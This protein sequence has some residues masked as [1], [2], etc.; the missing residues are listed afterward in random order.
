MGVHLVKDKFFVFVGEGYSEPKYRSELTEMMKEEFG[1]GPYNEQSLIRQILSFC[2]EYYIKNFIDICQKEPSITFYQRILELHEHSVE[3]TA[4][5][6]HQDLS[7]DVT[8]QYMASYRRILKYILEAGCDVPMIAGET[9]DRKFLERSDPKINDLMFLGNMII[10]CVELFAEQSM[11]DDVADVSFD[12][13]GFYVLSRRH[14]YEQV[15]QKIMENYEN[16]FSL[17]INENDALNDFK[18]AIL[19]CFNITYEQLSHMIASFHVQLEARGGHLVGICWDDLPNNLNRMFDVPLESAEL[20]F[21]GLTLSKNNKMDLLNLACKPYSIDRYLYKPILI[22]NVDNVDFGFLCSGA[23]AEAIT[24]LAT[25]AIPWGKA[26]LEWLSNSSFRKYVHAK[27]DQHDKWLEDP[28]EEIV[29]GLDLMYDRNIENLRLH[30]RTVSIN[31]Q[32]LGEIDFLVINPDLKKI[33]IIDCKHLLSRYDIVNQKNDFNAFVNNKRS[34]NQTMEKKV[35]WLKENIEILEEH[36]KVKYGD[37]S[38]SFTDYTLEGIFIINTPTFYMFNSEFR[39]YTITQV[40]DVFKGNFVD[41]TFTLFNDTG[42]D[43]IISHVS[44]P[45]FEKPE[46]IQIDPF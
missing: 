29:L 8:V 41:F 32:G 3:L 24:Q 7:D 39:I 45:Y 4:L 30:K 21:R 40:E 6:Q 37:E 42:N 22:W 10:T 35:N 33:Y 14:H 15:V 31:V 23:W 43:L 25:N 1:N 11:V 38:I 19:D 9:W 27:E 44:Y 13:D 20:F 34:Y 17:A 18:A 2:L 36:F 26:P 46:Y 12:E 5:F 28:V 16:A